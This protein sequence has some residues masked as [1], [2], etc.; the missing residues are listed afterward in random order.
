MQPIGKEANPSWGWNESDGFMA[1]KKSPPWGLTEYTGSRIEHAM[2]FTQVQGI[3]VRYCLVIRPRVILMLPP[4][5]LC[6]SAYLP[7]MGSP[8]STLR[9]QV[10]R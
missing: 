10:K 8:L 5:A 2:S 4:H 6:A 9:P 3:P 7:Q 1:S